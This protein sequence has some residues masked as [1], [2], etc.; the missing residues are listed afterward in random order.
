MHF[1]KC[2]LSIKWLLFFNINALE[3]IS[4]H[5][6][7]NVSYRLHSLVYVPNKLHY[8]SQNL[9]VSDPSTVVPLFYNPLF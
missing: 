3:T 9:R 6:T 7:Y 2:Y 1:F 4:V 8:E 5:Y